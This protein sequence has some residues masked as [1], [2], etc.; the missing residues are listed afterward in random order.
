MKPIEAPPP[1]GE[2]EHGDDVRMKEE[3]QPTSAEPGHLPAQPMSPEVDPMDYKAGNL[4][5]PAI[6]RTL[7]GQREGAMEAD[8]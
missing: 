5:K 8:L 3:E 1:D 4:D 7:L 2:T 6:F